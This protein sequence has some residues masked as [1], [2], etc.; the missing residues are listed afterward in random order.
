MTQN[1]SRHHDAYLCMYCMAQLSEDEVVIDHIMPLARGGSN[2]I[3]NLQV[4]CRRCN[5]IKSDREP[6]V[7]EAIIN[8]L[9][10]REWEARS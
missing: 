4:T 9:L 3:D 10:D 6:E 1:W 7:A 8:E 5:S 2:S